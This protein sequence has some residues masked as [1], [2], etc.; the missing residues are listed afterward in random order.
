MRGFAKPGMLGI[1]ILAAD[2]TRNLSSMG[3]GT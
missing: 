3:V 1:E 2:T